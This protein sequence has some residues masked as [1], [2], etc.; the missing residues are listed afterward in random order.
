MMHLKSQIIYKN[1]LELRE[2]GKVKVYKVQ[3]K[4]K[5]RFYLIRI[6][7]IKTKITNT[8]IITLTPKTM[9]YLCVHFTKHIQLL[10]A[11]SYIILMKEIK[12]YLNKWRDIPCS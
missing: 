5:S 1:L 6:E 3:H 2:F 9:K 4:R 12:L 8:I 10:Y 11:K 7:L